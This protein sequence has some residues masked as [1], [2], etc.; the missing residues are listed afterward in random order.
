GPG[1]WPAG[2]GPAAGSSSDRALQAHFQQLLGLDRELHRQLA[3]D[4]LA[5][6][7]DDQRDRVLLG[8]AAAAAVEQ[9]VLADLGG[10]GL[11]LD[12]GAGVPHLDVGE[13]VGA[14]LLADQQAVALGVVAR[15]FG[16]AVD[17]H[18]AA[19]GVLSAAGAYSLGHDLGLGAL[20]DV[21]H[22]GAGVG[23]LAVVG[24]GH[25][26]E[27]AHRVVAQQH[28]GRVLPGD[29]RAGLDLG[30]GHL[31]ARAP[32]LGALGHEVV[33]A[34]AAFLVAGVPVLHGRVL[35]LGIVQHH[36]PD[37]RRLQLVLGARRRG[38]ALEVGDVGAFLGDDQGA[39]ELPGMAGVDAEV[40][41][42]LHRAAHALGDEHEA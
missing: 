8:D 11:V 1:R 28:A 13:G 32:A 14:A 15:A 25:R 41:G 2:P 19:V 35:D 20:A 39:L 31:A 22:L 12:R 37:H 33:D 34:A 16:I 26:V 17:L 36:R 5:E 42:E 27:L 3:E 9:L 7:V 10:G 18:Q 24:Q 21:D 29:G 23:L 38:A 4:L 40:G 30:P 6:A